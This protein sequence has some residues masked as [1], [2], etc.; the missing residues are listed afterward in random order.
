M[1]FFFTLI[2]IFKN[3]LLITPKYPQTQKFPQVSIRPQKN[4]Q[5]NQ[6]NSKQP[7]TI[8][9]P[10]NKDQNEPNNMRIEEKAHAR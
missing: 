6:K 9:Y 3:F 7:K 10:Q 1:L 4:I 5:R 2:N 8:K